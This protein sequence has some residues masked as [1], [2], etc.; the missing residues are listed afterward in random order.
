MDVCLFSINQLYNILSYSSRLRFGPVTAISQLFGIVLLFPIV[1][2]FTLLRSVLHNVVLTLEQRDQH[3]VKYYTKATVNQKSYV[4]LATCG[5]N[6]SYI[7][8]FTIPT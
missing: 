7:S 8:A 2:R 4:Y 6:E 1:S 5:F 3:N